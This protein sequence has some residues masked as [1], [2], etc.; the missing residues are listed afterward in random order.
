MRIHMAA[1]RALANQ[2]GHVHVCPPAAAVPQLGSGIPTSLIQ[3]KGPEWLLD[4]FW[5][6]LCTSNQEVRN[7]G[8]GSLGIIFHYYYKLVHSLAAE[9]FMEGQLH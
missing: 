2:S 5:P 7:S 6:R 3:Y 1:G 4:N 9:L 8:L